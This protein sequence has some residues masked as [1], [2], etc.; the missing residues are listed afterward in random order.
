VLEPG[1]GVTRF[2]P[3][4][5]VGVPWLGWTCGRC[6]FC[7][8]GRENLCDRARFTGY[9]IDGG[10]AEETLAD[11]RSWLMVTEG[12]PD[13]QAAPLLCAGLIGYRSLRLTGD[14]TPLGLYGFGAAVHSICQVARWQ[15]RHVFAFT[16]PGGQ[17]GPGL[18]P[19]P[20]R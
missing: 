15:G 16:R 19:L 18:R 11:A 13:L 7:A 5:R 8:S 10:F 3:G 2:R 9:T 12:Y 4:Q 17:P 6:R 1:R 14:A 20:R